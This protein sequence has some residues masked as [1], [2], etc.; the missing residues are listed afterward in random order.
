MADILR[1]NLQ[2][3]ALQAA[4]DGHLASTTQSSSGTI[5]TLPSLSRN[6]ITASNRDGLFLFSISSIDLQNLHWDQYMDEDLFY[7]Q[8]SIGNWKYRSPSASLILGS[9]SISWGV[10]DSDK[11]L[12]SI[13]VPKS[14][15]DAEYLKVELYRYRDF[16]ADY[17]LG[18][19]QLELSALLQRYG[20]SCDMS[21]A[22][23]DPSTQMGVIGRIVVAAKTVDIPATVKIDVDPHRYLST[24]VLHPGLKRLNQ[25]SKEKTNSSSTG[26]YPLLQADKLSFASIFNDYNSTDGHLLRTLAGDISTDEVLESGYRITNDDSDDQQQTR[27]VIKPLPNFQRAKHF[28][29]SKMKIQRQQV[30]RFASEV[31]SLYS[32]IDQISEEKLGIATKRF[33]ES[34]SRYQEY[35]DTRTRIEDE[36]KRIQERMNSTR[37]GNDPPKEPAMDEILPAAL[38]PMIPNIANSREDKTRPILNSTQMANTIEAINNG[39]MDGKDWFQ[40]FGS[41]RAN[42]KQI[43][44][45]TQEIQQ[46]NEFLE[47]RRNQLL[48]EQ[49][50]AI[51]LYND[52]LL[53]YERE[54][55]RRKLEYNKLKKDLRKVHLKLDVCSECIE[56]IYAEY[57]VLELDLNTLASLLDL[58]KKSQDRYHVI[59]M[60]QLLEKE[61][62]K[63][64][65]LSLKKRFLQLMN[66]RRQLLNLPATTTDKAKDV[67]L[68]EKVESALR[69]IEYELLDIKESLVGEGVKLRLIH[70]EELST[71]QYEYNRLIFLR[72]VIEQRACVDIILDRSR[73]EILHLYDS[74][75]KILMIEAEKDDA[76]LDTIDNL[77][78][79]YPK[80][81]V[82]D[83][84]EMV[85]CL[86]LIDLMKNK[87]RLINTIRQTA[88]TSQK[89]IL[90]V[91][92]I[93]WTEDYLQVR[94]S[95]CENSDYDRSQQLLGYIVRWIIG[96]RVKLSAQEESL[97]RERFELQSQISAFQQQLV[98]QTLSHQAEVDSIRSSAESVI[99]YFQQQIESL[100]V[101]SQQK[102]VTLEQSI[103]ELNQECHHV[104]EQM[105]SQAMI[106]EDKNKILW[107]MVTTQQDA[108]Q[109][110]TAKLESIIDEREKII[111][112]AKL[113]Y[114]RIRTQLRSERKYSANLLFI[115]QAQRGSIKHAE[116]RIRDIFEQAKQREIVL[117]LEKKNLRHEIFQYVYAITRLATDPDE[118]F[119]FFAARLAN[120]CGSK[121]VT[122]DLLAQNNNAVMVLAAMCRSP[123]P[124]IRKY[125]SR[126][127]GSIGWNGYVEDRVLVWD[128]MMHWKLFQKKV[129]A[130]GEQGLEYQ[131]SYKAY[132]EKAKEDALLDAQ[133]NVTAEQYA[134]LTSDDL[135][136]QALTRDEEFTLATGLTSAN[137]SVRTIIKQ[138]RQYA[139]RAIRRIEGP[140]AANQRLI[141]MQDGIIPA[142]LDICLQEGSSDWEVARNAALAICIASYEPMNHHE[143]SQNQKC[144]QLLVQLCSH[145]DAEIQAHAA[146]TIANLCHNDEH[147]QYIF[148]QTASTI[149]ILLSVCASSRVVDSLE[150]VTAALAN[151][152][153][154]CDS[155]CKKVLEE[156]GL[157]TVIRLIKQCYTENLL[158]SDQNEEI[159]A[160]AAEMLANVSRYHID[161]DQFIDQF[162]DEVLDSLV[163]MS[164]SQNIQVKRHVPLV[165]GNIAQSERCRE[166]LGKCGIIESLFLALEDSDSDPTVQANI[167]WSLCNLMWHPPNQERAGRFM[168]E[169]LT[170]MALQPSSHR[171]H[172]VQIHIYTLLGNM[173]YYNNANRVR[174]LEHENSMDLLMKHL[175]PSQQQ[176]N[177]ESDLLIV[178]NSMRSMLSLS[179]LDHVTTWIINT[180]HLTLFL[181]YLRKPYKS[182]DLVRFALGIISN[183]SVS[184]EHRKLVFAHGGLDILLELSLH[185]DRH[186]IDSAQEVIQ[187]L[188]DVMSTETLSKKKEAIG[189]DRMIELAKSEDSLVRAVAAE[190]IGE[191]IWHD[192]SKQ[193]Q[194][195][196]QGGMDALLEILR[197]VD[198]S[199]DSVLP[200]LWSLRNL[201]HQNS[202]GQHQFFMKDGISSIIDL[203][204]RCIRQEFEDQVEKILEASLACIATAIINHTG[205]S[206]RLLV[207]GLQSLVDI[208]EG[209]ILTKIIE[210]EE[211]VYAE[212]TRKA[213][214]NDTVIALA[215]TILLMLGPYNYIICKNCSKKQELSGTNCVVCGHRLRLD[216]ADK[217]NT[218]KQLAKHSRITNSP[219]K[220][221]LGPINLHKTDDKGLDRVK[222]IKAGLPNKSRTMPTAS[223][224]SSPDHV[225]S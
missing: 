55:K 103:T 135:S 51:D 140:N 128:A 32:I 141:N 41:Y 69:T 157:R 208:V 156:D 29:R 60:K 75:E 52:E 186:I 20:S 121:K 68:Y 179:Y 23:C 216:V 48:V 19:C 189:L 63:K 206:R 168:H 61:R 225:K 100:T 30:R 212:I 84:K 31:S 125:A 4:I 158:D 183:L 211:H 101:E 147:A 150:A 185:N 88:A 46:R 129:V 96:Q 34:K 218:N 74:K 174:F 112:Q 9:Q 102:Q 110:L 113:N 90:D 163:F 89:N 119:E 95:W 82:W 54:E 190:S 58:H 132:T 123:R 85:A 182:N 33:E 210:S 71:S 159:Q 28:L 66:N 98:Q 194:V 201:L 184:F 205:N 170:R 161:D 153:C 72:N 173:L 47:V 67:A 92:S 136:S 62:L 5:L 214:K 25:D 83:S 3:K 202:E 118:L 166:V 109:H 130:Q 115:I 59:H 169:V 160:N 104:R 44:L 180:E 93:K 70:N 187:R 1:S 165:I 77:G 124:L 133:A 11:P 15:I 39:D 73:Y 50:R 203:F 45:L 21:A 200:S 120:L 146:V 145:E 134:R 176:Q 149:N 49:Q 193:S 87:I 56:E 94:D 223:A 99:K 219:N 80:D 108:V 18:E 86:R 204:H 8:C 6:E 27:S 131:Q 177:S 17:L 164:A 107:A 117:Q 220:K 215:K 138:R 198:E 111:I 42:P 175:D 40:L 213:Y 199:Y 148:G 217:A 207:L 191:E 162:D 188:E 221:E 197:K 196:V 139:L 106:F 43:K 154:Y 64:A 209:H 142:L 172:P 14:R 143:M 167:L 16:A 155:N 57:S 126:A 12:T 116:Q 24:I 195:M 53:Y 222:K 181:S 91:V 192:P 114:D 151:M 137:A 2:Q 36:I 81:K 22:V 178:E 79:R 10:G 152:T 171:Y 65:L 26:E 37:T 38:V 13:Y 144:V 76:G 35:L 105:T 7:I 78:E 224:G 127:L 122:N 97:T